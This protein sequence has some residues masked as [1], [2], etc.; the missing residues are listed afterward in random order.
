MAA[1]IIFITGTDT[2][3]GK[4][5]VTG[6]LLSHLRGDGC[7]ALA[8]KPFC[9][10]GPEDV[11]ILSALQNNELKPRE[12]NPFYYA[13]PLAPLVAARRRRRSV[14]IG[15]VIKRIQAISRRCDYLL[16]EGA[17]GLL[18]PL[19]EG[20]AA[21]E[22]IKETGET[23]ICVAPNKLGAI[24]QSMLAVRSLER[25]EGQNFKL[26]LMDPQRRDVSARD[27]AKVLRELIAPASV[28]EIPHFRALAKMPMK[29]EV[30]ETFA[31][32]SKKI[33]KTLAEFRQ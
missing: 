11:E 17:G 13:E 29:S 12:M 26:V 33:K 7:H 9:S 15:E 3:V 1:K 20:F 32:I 5:M 10:G 4:T 16:I 21:L 23:V 25:I 18:T 30:F 24:N 28:Y 31:T 27:N 2:C 19:G 6:L 8:M 22:L 14:R